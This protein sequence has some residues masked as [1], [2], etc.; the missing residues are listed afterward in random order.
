MEVVTSRQFQSADRRNTMRT[1]LTQRSQ[2]DWARLQK[3]ESDWCLRATAARSC[4]R[5]EVRLP[6]HA[7]GVI[8]AM[9]EPAN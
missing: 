7:G 5:R 3:L 6:V 2:K 8:F 4:G 1:T 9:N